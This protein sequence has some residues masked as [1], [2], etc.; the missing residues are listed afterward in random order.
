MADVPQLVDAALQHHRAGRLVEA[1]A[2]YR[3]ALAIDPK[4][5]DALYLLGLIHFNTDRHEDGVVLVQLAI[6][7][8]DVT[9]AYHLTLAK[10]LDA[11]G[12]INGALAS[13]RRALNLVPDNADAH[14]G[15]GL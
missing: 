9:P 7:S 10:L 6:A 2:P 14:I 4:H 5:P 8:S 15:L 3:Q 1:E 13:Y 12:D 11:T